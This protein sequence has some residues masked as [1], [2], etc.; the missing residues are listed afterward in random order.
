MGLR[1]GRWR[2]SNAAILRASALPA[3]GS[4]SVLRLIALLLVAAPV[5][6]QTAP[7]PDTTAAAD[8]VRA[9]PATPQT[10]AQQALARVRAAVADSAAFAADGPYRPFPAALA[11]VVWAAPPATADA[12]DDLLAIRRAGARAVRTGLVTDPLVLEAATRLGLSL[13][14]DLPVDGLPA[15]FL[16][17][18][19]NEVAQILAEALDLARPYAAARHFG[20]ARGSDTSDRASRAYFEALTELAHERGAAGTQTYYVSRFVRD[21]RAG[22]SVDVVLIDARERDPAAALR[23]W[24]ATHETPVGLAAIGAGVRPGR[25]GGW[26]TTGSEAAQGRTLENA[27]D[28]LLTFQPP[29]AVAFVYRWRDALEDERQDQR[30]EVA[31]TRFGL[32]DADDQPR[33]AFEVARGFWT[34]R[35]RVFAFDAGQPAE[36]ALSAS[37]LLLLGWGLVLG[38]GALYAVTPRLSALAPRYFG[39][40][41]LYRD[42]VK[43][44]FDLSALETTGLGSALSLS[45]G[46]VGTSALRALGRTDALTA[47]TAAWSTEAQA[48]LTRLLGQPILLVGVL[49]LV[50]GAWLLLNLIWL[51]VLA[52]R[53]RVR[54]AQAL[55]LAVW[56]RWAWLPLMIVALVLGG[57]DDQ[58]ATALAPTLLIL[59]VLVEVVAGWRMVWDLQAI[60]SVP[61]ARAVLLGFGLPFLL[62]AGGLV[63]LALASEAEAGFL[64][65]LATRS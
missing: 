44:G 23:L 49:A 42:A 51:N 28:D 32:L 6:A 34:G 45:A 52:G 37:P 43:R 30:A 1:A 55:S 20:L 59:A 46:V 12:I 3:L 40:R 41:D 8:P 14:Q 53:R 48:L 21:D 60:K 64:W 63:W 19:T 7:P 35:Q 33:S 25:G 16:V 29:P 56:C 58:L 38:L 11:G 13:W 62:A 61:P 10:P 47:A 26:R 36:R 57:V 22:R 5:W 4:S 54:P 15:P 2:G 17:A 39:R 9:V 27:L 31:G 24:R 65:H 50:Y 18:Q